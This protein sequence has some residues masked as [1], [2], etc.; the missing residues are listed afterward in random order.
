M[1]TAKLPLFRMII[2]CALSLSIGWG[3]RGNFGH[4]YG[5]MIPGALTAIAAALISGRDDWWPRV[6]YFGMFGALGWSFGGSISYMMVI[7][8]THSGHL[9]TQAYGYACLFL[10]GFLWAALGGAGTALPACLDRE[11]LTSL[12]VPVLTVCATWYVKDLVIPL[13][14]HAGYGDKRHLSKL[15]WYDTSWLAVLTALVAVLLLAAIRRRVCWGT[16]LILHMTIGWWAAFLFMVFMVDVLG[17]EFRMTPPRGDNWVGALGMTAGT[18]LFFMRQ[19]MLPVVQAMLIAGFVGGFGFAA[20]TFFKLAEVKYLPLVLTELFGGGSWQTNWHS[21]LEQTYG[22]INGIGIA[23]AMGFL[24][25]R[26]PRVVDEPRTRRWTEIIAVAFVVLLITYLNVIKDVPNWIQQHAVPERLYGWATVYWFNVGYA[27]LAVAVIGLL[28]RHL[29]TRIPLLPESALGKGQLLYLILLWWVVVGN[30]MHAIPSFAEQRLITEGVI[31]VNAVICTVLIL[32]WPRPTRLPDLAERAITGR[33]L[34]WTTVVG[35]AALLA[36]VALASYGTRAMFGDQ[37][38]G[39]GGYHIRFGP[40][41]EGGK[42]DINK[43]H[44]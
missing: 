10:I 14:D 8:Y 32:L 12:F 4:E 15:Y 38:A 21:V 26:V 33:S 36:T 9:P 6:G 37:F 24:S 1:P 39:Q 41:A 3:I 31:H 29:C 40:N 42:P 7:S 27:L 20:A 22:L 18:L 16:S 44:P 17:I 11:R 35:L 2:L 28:A 19:R 30:L 43:K 25:R 5:A 13:I 23:L 34:M